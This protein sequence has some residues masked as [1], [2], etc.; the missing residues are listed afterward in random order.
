M[1]PI[2]QSRRLVDILQTLPSDCWSEERSGSVGDIV[3]EHITPN[4][5][6]CR[7][8]SLFVAIRGTRCDGAAYIP[9]AVR[10]GAVCVA[11]EEAQATQLAGQESTSVPVLYVKDS[12]RFMSI[13]SQAF[14]DYPARRLSVV[15]ITGTS[16]KT[17]TSYITQRLLECAGIP[18]AMLG[19][20]GYFMPDGEAFPPDTLPA[21]TPE[22]FL[23][24]EYLHEA[25]RRGAQVAVLEVSSFALA[26]E[27]VSGMSFAVAV[28]T[29]FSEDHLGYHHTMNDYLMAKLKLFTG[30]AGEST[31]VLN[32]DDLAFPAFKDACTTGHIVTYSSTGLA[33]LRASNIKS[34]RGRTTFSLSLE[35]G[36]CFP[37]D[38]GVGPAYQVSNCLAALGA[39]RAVAPAVGIRQMTAGLARDIYIPGR[40]ERIVCGQPFEVIVDYA[41]TPEEFTALFSAVKSVITGD[42]IVVFGSVG[43]DDR[44]KRPRMAQLAERA[45]RWSYVTVEDP[46]GEDAG[47]AVADIVRGF[48]TGR[49]SVLKDRRDA[50]RAAMALARPGDAVLVLGRGHEQVMYYQHDNVRFDD[51]DEC[52][53]ALSELNYPSGP[54]LA[55]QTDGDAGDS[56]TV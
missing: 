14:F 37:V 25:L 32:A 41:H 50:I 35:D 24:N 39:V 27:R 54:R 34:E 1:K 19:T 7:E 42:M 13:L 18:C 46:R 22:P 45:C 47:I 30:L 8:G 21:T 4:S 6:S 26:F 55:R 43:A 52:R 9:E 36:T 2:I 5:Q 33:D 44:E 10:R 17:S 31:A 53:S 12:R 56:A 48:E 29:N 11:L 38:L 51:R 16:G 28:F 40:Y 15:G 23:L 20:T 49:Y 3:V